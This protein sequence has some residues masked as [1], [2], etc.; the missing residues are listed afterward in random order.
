[1]AKRNDKTLGLVQMAI[2]IAIIFIL[3]FGIPP[4]R[5]GPL[6]I[7][8]AVIPVGIGSI[9]FGYK[10][11]AL[12]GFCLGLTLFL[13]N[14]LMPGIASFV[15]TPFYSAGDIHGNAW[16]LVVSFVPRILTGVIP[17]F[18]YNGVQ[19]LFKNKKWAK[20]V[21]LTLA[22]FIAPVTNSFFVLSF[23]YIFFGAQYS[24]AFGKAFGVLLSSTILTNAIPEAIAGA[25]IIPTTCSV[26]AKT[27]KTN[28]TQK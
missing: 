6:S 25:V 9:M 5:I 2:L 21:A 19:K 16:S 22:G 28:N 13:A 11:G 24:S 10:K 27:V 18:V 15:F 26:L 17:H 7:T 4:I 20:S 12:L 8:L 23:I 14:T 1:M 3:V